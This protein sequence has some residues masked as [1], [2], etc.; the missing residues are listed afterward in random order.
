MIEEA[1]V[2]IEEAYLYCKT[3]SVDGFELPELC[4]MPEEEIYYV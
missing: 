1:M 4:K 2:L 3:N